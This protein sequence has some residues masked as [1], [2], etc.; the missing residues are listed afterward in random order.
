[1]SSLSFL[2]DL[3]SRFPFDSSPI[4]RKKSKESK[5]ELNGEE[6]ISSFSFSNFVFI[7]SWF[8]L[9]LQILNN[10][11][12]WFLTRLREEKDTQTEIISFCC[13]FS[14]FTMKLNTKRK[15]FDIRK[16]SRTES[17]LKSLKQRYEA[18]MLQEIGQMIWFSSLIYLLAAHLSVQLLHV[19]S[20]AH[21][22][23]QIFLEN[24][25]QK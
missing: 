11:I 3:Y 6:K 9:W 21:E 7:F 14:R 24:L 25:S 10:S 18:T 16:R 1:M 22:L 17:F 23:P 4:L 20:T 2:W 12:H 8:S 15:I 5:V 13:C 19:H